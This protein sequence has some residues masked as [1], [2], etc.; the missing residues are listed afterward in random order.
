MCALFWR[1]DIN[2]TT[3]SPLKSPNLYQ[4]RYDLHMPVV[5][6]VLVLIK[7]TGVNEIVERGATEAALEASQRLAQ[8]P[9]QFNVVLLSVLL[10]KRRMP[11]G[12]NP[13]L[14]RKT[15]RERTYYEVARIFANESLAGSFLPY[16]VTKNTALV[17]LVVICRGVDLL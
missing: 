3:R 2:V 7:R 11:L 16:D 1:Y 8:D 9:S 14:I 10:K 12:Q 17:R 4:L 5:G 6:V 13:G 15:R